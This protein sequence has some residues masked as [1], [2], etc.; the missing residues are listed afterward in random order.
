MND[1]QALTVRELLRCSDPSID[2]MNIDTSEIK[3]LSD[4][5]PKDG[6]IDL[7]NAEVLATKYLRGAGTGSWN[8]DA[9]WSTTSSAGSANTTKPVAADAVI[10]DSGSAATCTIDVGNQACTSIVCAGF[11]G[12]LTFTTFNITT[13]GTVTLASGM[14][15][16]VGTTEKP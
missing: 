2:P 10:L 7:N 13:T 6:N 11:T 8:T 16:N 3:A 1:R 5:M 14:T 12:T 4:A 15:I 9:S